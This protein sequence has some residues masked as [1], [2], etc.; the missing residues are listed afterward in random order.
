MSGK[1]H[2]HLSK[3]AELAPEFAPAVKRMLGKR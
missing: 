1:E 3:E 2:R